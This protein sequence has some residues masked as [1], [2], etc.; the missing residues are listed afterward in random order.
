MHAYLPKRRYARDW[1]QTHASRSRIFTSS[2]FIY[3]RH[4][5]DWVKTHALFKATDI[6]NGHKMGFGY[7]FS[8]VSALLYLMFT[9]TTEL[10]FENL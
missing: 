3:Y 1:V 4:A 2:L 7:K 8:K 10:T 5:R 6:R 9:A